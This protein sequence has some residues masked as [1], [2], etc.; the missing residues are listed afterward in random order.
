MVNDL[1]LGIVIIGRNEGLR[2]KRCLGSVL[3]DTRNTV[4]YVDSGST[5]QSVESA[6]SF[7]VNVVE[8]DMT[9]PFTAARARN[10]GYKKL[11]H[12]APDTEF[13]QFV[14]GDCAI[15][16]GWL[17]MA[18]DFLRNNNSYAVV[19]GRLREVSRDS[20]IYNRLC[21]IEWDAVVGDV[22]NCGGIAVYRS[23]ALVQSNGFCEYIIAGEEPELCYRIRQ[24]GWKIHR[25][26]KDMAYHDA[27]MTH[28]SQWW[29]RATRSG[30]AYA[31]GMYLH[32]RSPERYYVKDSISIW[33]WGFVI[34]LIILT[35]TLSVSFYFLSMF[36]LYPIQVLKISRFQRKRGYSW[37]ESFL[38]AFFCVLGKFAQLSG[39]LK[40]FWGL[41]TGKRTKL[42]EYK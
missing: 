29:K 4:V 37:H 25:L 27:D 39:Q 31:E 15:S 36:L 23:E 26:D 11:L 30:H 33:I 35:T 42:I 3:N 38:Y 2:L 40:F 1:Q 7:G 12:I 28:F 9:I 22:K 20:T 19:C 5:D 34:P 13:V 6:H 16:D 24:A 8:L 21:D 10:T 18:V 17:Q 14:D 32:G 41:L